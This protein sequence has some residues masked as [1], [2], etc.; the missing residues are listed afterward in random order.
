MD[1]ITYYRRRKRGRRNY[2][3]DLDAQRAAVDQYLAEHDGR[4]LAEYTEIEDGE[5]I[6]RPQLKA[7]IEQCNKI[8]ATLLVASSYRMKVNMKFLSMLRD[9]NFVV[10][11]DESISTPTLP[12]IIDIARTWAA[13]QSAKVRER[14]KGV[15]CGA[16]RPGH[17]NKNNKD[18][19]D[20]AIKKATKASV[21]ARQDRARAAYGP[22]IPLMKRWKA[23]EG[24]SFNDV[25]K[26]LNED[27][28]LTTAGKPFTASAV[29]R[30]MK[31][32]D[33]SKD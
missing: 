31:A 24:T 25:A 28:Y 29:H 13:E 15:V 8:G 14:M 4:S 32:H 30:I 10:A 1:H 26:W 20:K 33:D 27:G 23:Q 12:V 3:L 9:V 6:D 11:D 7:A 5:A 18:L 22:L 19:F 2:G 17:R 16:A 21:K